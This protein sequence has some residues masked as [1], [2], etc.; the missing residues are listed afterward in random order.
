MQLFYFGIAF[1]VCS[2][3][4]LTLVYKV[5]VCVSH[6][7]HKRKIDNGYCADPIT[8]VE[9][10][11]AVMSQSFSPSAFRGVSDGDLH[12]F[13]ASAISPPYSRRCS[14]ASAVT[15]CKVHIPRRYTPPPSY[16]E[17]MSHDTLSI[18]I[19]SRIRTFSMA[20]NV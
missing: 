6:R 4:L 13:Q 7:M 3:I 19:P 12:I 17:A 9:V 5:Y 20:S 2:A 16:E 10:E 18:S 14:N 8:S 15:V 11:R 1:I